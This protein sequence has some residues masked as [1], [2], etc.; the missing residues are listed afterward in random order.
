LESYSPSFPR[1]KRPV[2]LRFQLVTFAVAR[3]VTNT[4]HRMI[5]PFLPVFAKGLG[6]DLEAIALAVT[7]RSALG[8]ASPAF[9]SLA[10]SRGRRVAML[11]GLLAFV[12]GM[13]LVTVWPTYPALFLALL[14]A[15]AGKLIYDPAMQ[16]YIGDRVHYTQ[17]GLAIAITEFSW[18]AA[19]LLGAPVIGW[20]IARS[21]AW[22]APFPLLAVGGL[23]SAAVLWW[24]V[25]SDAVQ[26][27]S[28]L[29]LA[30]G[31]RTVLVCTP[32]VAALAVSLLISASNE[33]VGIV[34]GAWIE[35]AFGL[36]VT[37][38]GAASAVIGI[39]ELA[40]EGSVAGFVDRL[41]KR[42]AV[43]LGIALNAL[44][45]LLL[46]VL[47]VGVGGA[48]VGLFLFY[49]TFE[50]AVVSAIPLMTELLP[51]ARATLMAW[52]VAAFAGGRM[53]GSL[54][55]PQL[56]TLGLLANGATAAVF[57]VIALAALLLFVR[58]D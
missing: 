41:G 26:L 51:G 37:A 5:Y 8:L 45:C 9:G 44:A 27:G 43:V 11:A 23:L 34:Y 10:G 57:D 19:F 30:Q 36:K 17:R 20:L 33:T 4:G 12:G 50:F 55:G 13:T 58:Q 2:R 40:G 54:I 25:P 15:S 14:L 1:I 31:L 18:S 39:A 22:Q 46:P 29:S 42:R 38:L 49:I 3:T 7:A 56:F 24:A 53:L 35:D 32:A 48:L 52:N 6:V 47:G 28:R 16:A 21:G